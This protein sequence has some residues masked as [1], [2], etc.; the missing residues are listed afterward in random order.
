MLLVNHMQSMV[1]GLHGH[2]LHGEVVILLP[3]NNQELEV[4][5]VQTLLLLD[6]VH[7]VVEV[8]QLHKL[9]I[10]E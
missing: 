4:E 3:E 7:I 10:V 2:G 5:R 1:D 9:E 6:E 8:H